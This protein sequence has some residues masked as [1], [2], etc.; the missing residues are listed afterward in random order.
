MNINILEFC[1]I[2]EIN[3]QPI[4][5]KIDPETNK[6]ILSMCFCEKNIVICLNRMILQK[7]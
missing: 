7:I 3:W 4:E 5:L 2:F 1:E 6:K